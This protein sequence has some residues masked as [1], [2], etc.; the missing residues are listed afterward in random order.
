MFLGDCL[1]DVADFIVNGSSDSN[2]EATGSDGFDDPSLDAIGSD[3]PA[4]LDKVFFAT[5]APSHAESAV[6]NFISECKEMGIDVPGLFPATGA[7]TVAAVAWAVEQSG[8]TDPAT[9]ADTIRN[10]DSVPVLTVD[11]ISFKDTR[12]YAQ[13]T[14]PVIGYK[15]GKRVLISN[16]IPANTPTNWN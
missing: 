14:I 3:D 6:V 2:S 16:E 5:L 11:S 10:A 7:D 1:E 15:D 9:I 4:I 8:S 13:R 12:T